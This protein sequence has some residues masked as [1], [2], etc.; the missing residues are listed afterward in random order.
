M[1]SPQSKAFWLGRNLNIIAYMKGAGHADPQEPSFLKIQRI[2]ELLA[3]TLNVRAGEASAS[4]LED[5]LGSLRED[6][7]LE[8][9]LVHSEFVAKCFAFGFDFSSWLNFRGGYDEQGQARSD[10]DLQ[11]VEDTLRKE[12]AEIGLVPQWEASLAAARD[13]TLSD[14]KFKELVGVDILT[15]MGEI[16]DSTTAPVIKTQA[17][18]G[19]K[20]LFVVMP[21]VET[22]PA[23]VD[24]LDAIQETA[25]ALQLEGNRVDQLAIPGKITDSIVDGLKT[26]SYVVVDLTHARPNVYWEAGFTHGLGKVPIY[27]ARKGTHPEFDVK[28]YPVIYFASMK[29]LREKLEARLKLMAESGF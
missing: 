10:V 29:E 14:E 18:A 6:T 19:P 1:D 24:V 4:K 15:Q 23:L 2:V 28:D 12:A 5:A 9:A 27:I 21:M 3:K 20:R 16:L 17:A 25:K 13:G 22:D 26:A 7:K 8:L 11:K